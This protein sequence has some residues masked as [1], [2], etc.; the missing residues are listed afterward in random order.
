ML[1]VRHIARVC[2]A[3]N[4]AY[5]AALGDHSQPE[6]GAAPQWQRESA[7]KGVEFALAYPDSK[8]SDSHESWLAQ[9]RAEGWKYGPVKDAEKK[10]HPCFVP[11]DQL[12]QE[13]RA[14]DYIFLS[15]VRA[16]HELNAEPGDA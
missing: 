14:K 9:K 6:W 5:C 13:Q 7:I 10:E 4:R 12:P 2:H 11:Y 1:K 15:V 16:M 8:P 3:V